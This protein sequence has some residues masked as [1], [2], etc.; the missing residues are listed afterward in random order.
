MAFLNS[1]VDFDNL[2]IGIGWFWWSIYCYYVLMLYLSFDDKECA[3]MIPLYLMKFD[4]ME[5]MIGE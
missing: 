5:F 2:Y 3:L 4:L 1:Y